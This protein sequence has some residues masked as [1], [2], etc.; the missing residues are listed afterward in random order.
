MYNRSIRP[1]PNTLLIFTK[2]IFF[3]SL[4][5]SESTYL[6]PAKQRHWFSHQ[7][8]IF[9][10]FHGCVSVTGPMLENKSGIAKPMV[11]GPWPLK[12]DSIINHLYFEGKIV[13]FEVWKVLTSVTNFAGSFQIYDLMLTKL[14]TEQWLKVLTKNNIGF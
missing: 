8:F 2:T 6:P 11:P 3:F 5:D 9:A 4:A 13:I 7:Y 10:W 14:L 12:I 1:N